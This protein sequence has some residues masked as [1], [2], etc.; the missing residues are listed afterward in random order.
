MDDKTTVPQAPGIMCP[1]CGQRYERQAYCPACGHDPSGFDTLTPVGGARM[2]G[3]FIANLIRMVLNKGRAR[4][5][6]NRR[7]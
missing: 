3:T 6:Q 7:Q 1:R 5:P 2:E 4:R